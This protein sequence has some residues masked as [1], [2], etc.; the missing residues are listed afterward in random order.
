M[1]KCSFTQNIDCHDQ[2]KT[3]DV[4][5]HFVQKDH[6]R[7]VFHTPNETHKGGSK[8]RVLEAS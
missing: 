4:F 8:L 7:T 2:D 6:N 1:Q 5:R 3:G